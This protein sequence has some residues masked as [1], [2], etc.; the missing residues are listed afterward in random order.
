MA[1]G[2]ELERRLENL[3]TP[4]KTKMGITGVAQLGG[5]HSE[6][7]WI[8][9][10]GKQLAERPAMMRRRLIAAGGGACGGLPSA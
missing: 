4:H 5:G 7:H 9:R 3:Y 8:D 2:V 1:T 10:S 6:G